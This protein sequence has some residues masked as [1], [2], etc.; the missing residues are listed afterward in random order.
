LLANGVVV[1]IVSG[2]T[3]NGQAAFAIQIN[4]TTGAITVEQYLSLDHPVNPDPNDAISMLANTLGATVTVTDGDGD[5]VTSSSVDISS[6]IS[7]LDDGPVIGTVQSQQTDNNPARAA[8][9]GTVPFSAGADGFG[10]ATITANVTGLKSGGFNL[11]TQ[12]VGNV[13]TAYQ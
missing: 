11:V 2:G 4:S 3:F 7:F 1:G 12:Q 13:L 8:A 6:K 9:V 5:V 10:S